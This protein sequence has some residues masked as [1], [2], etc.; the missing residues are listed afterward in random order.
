MGLITITLFL[1]ILKLLCHVASVG[2]KH[3][4]SEK[5]DIKNEIYTV[6]FASSYKTFLN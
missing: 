5:E 3:Y 2:F 4:S 1:R 6:E